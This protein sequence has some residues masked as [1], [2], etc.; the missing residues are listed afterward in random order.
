MSFLTEWI[1][2]IILL[3][4][5]A[6]VIELLLPGNQFQN[7]V[8]MVIGLLILM[9]ML[10]PVL[11]IVKT[12]FNEVFEHLDLPAAATEGEL[13]KSIEKN[14]SEIEEK[15]RAYILEQM[16]VQMKKQVQ[17]ELEKTYGIVIHDLQVQ[18]DFQRGTF[19]PEDITNARV[20]LARST[21][22][23]NV[24]A[25]EEVEVHVSDQGSEDLAVNQ[26]VLDRITHF[27]ASRWQLDKQQLKIVME[28]GEESS[29]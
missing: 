24:S 6:S 19:K 21:E 8:K 12:D 5:L 23:G 11:K 13:K 26:A 20:V 16:A 29:Q 2:N 1:T 28:G 22:K 3:V 17:E 14:K 18:M 4:L 10:S 25:V 27:L 7:Y 9:A 15:Q